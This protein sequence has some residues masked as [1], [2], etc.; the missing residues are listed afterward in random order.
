M[1]KKSFKIKK[2]FTNLLD[3]AISFLEE[4]KLKIAPTRAD[5]PDLAKSMITENFPYDL[6]VLA[7]FINNPSILP[8]NESYSSVGTVIGMRGGSEDPSA[9]LKVCFFSIADL[10]LSY[11]KWFKKEELFIIDRPL[12]Q[13]Q[14]NWS[15][16]AEILKSLETTPRVAPDPTPTKKDPEGGSGNGGPT[17][18]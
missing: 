16:A 1:K 8:V 18:H 7:D 6:V 5:N 10:E 13:L 12:A 3:L 9:E 17:I 4:I 11:S 14:K 15:Q 2:S